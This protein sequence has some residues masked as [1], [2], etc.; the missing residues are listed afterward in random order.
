VVRGLLDDHFSRRHNRAGILWALLCFSIW[1]RGYVETSPARPP[2]P[3]DS[4]YVPHAKAA[5]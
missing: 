2:V 4:E 5:R 1:H 3:E